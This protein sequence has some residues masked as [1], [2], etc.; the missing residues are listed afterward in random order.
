MAGTAG[1]LVKRAEE[2]SQ[3]PSP[4]QP[5]VLSLN[6]KESELQAYGLDA[7]RFIRVAIR[8][9]S[10]NPEL[11]KAAVANRTQLIGAC[12]EMA[13]WNLDPSVSNECWLIPYKGKNGTVINPQLGYKG[14]LK[15][16]NRAA[17]ELKNPL[18]QLKAVDIYENDEF[19]YSDGFSPDL[20]FKPAVGDRGKLVAFIAFAEDSHGRRYIEGP[21]SV[22]EMRRH[23]A[24]FSKAKYGPL[25]DEENFARYGIKT[26]LRL[27]C[28]RQLD[29]TPVISEAIDR[30]IATEQ[31]IDVDG[32]TLP[33]TGDDDDIIE[34]EIVEPAGG[35]DEHI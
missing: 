7:K 17:L 32:V 13:Q 27:L 6:K 15:L 10:S 31:E 16:A 19:E 23:K 34:G 18:K 4:L 29:L 28:T 3:A 12:M 21:M 35:D 26:M 11:M 2:K 8:H 20:K 25:A 1:E 9:I 22:T 24:R 14:L 30:D 33:E 5:F